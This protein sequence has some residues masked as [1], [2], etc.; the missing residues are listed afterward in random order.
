MLDSETIAAS[1][2]MLEEARRRKERI[3][4]LTILNPDMTIDDAY[5]IQ[6][7][8]VARRT[9]EGR[10]VIGHKV[11]L[12]SK[13]MQRSSGL[14]EPD[15]GTLLDDTIH[16]D[17]CELPADAYISPRVEIELAFVLKKNLP[18]PGCTLFDVI[19]ATDFVIP[20]FEVLDSRVHRVDAATGQKRSVLDNI[21]DN[22]G[23]SGIVMGGNPFRPDD[24]DMRWVSALCYQNGRVVESGVAAAVMNHPAHAVAWLANKLAAHGTILAAGQIIL[25]GSFIRILD[26][27][28]GDTFS[29]DYGPYGL[30]SLHFT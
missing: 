18:G 2:G 15:Y 3:R 10:S 26:A 13:A 7:A 9:A 25:S 11:G 23:Y 20:A 5:A 19:N 14:D 29:A 1:A 27:A 12:T 4:P 16:A 8:W 22:A 17:G 24:T 6:S 28:K 21:S 30:V